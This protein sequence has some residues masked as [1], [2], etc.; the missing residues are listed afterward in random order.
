MPKSSGK[1][2]GPDPLERTGA[3]CSN[4]LRDMKNR[5]DPPR[6]QNGRRA[7]PNKWDVAQNLDTG[8]AQTPLETDDGRGHYLLKTALFSIFAI[9]A[10]MV[11]AP[12]G[13]AGSLPMI[14]SLLLFAT[15]FAS[16]I[17]GLHNPL[18][19][20]HP[21]RYAFGALLL[22]TCASYMAMFSGWTGGSTV[23]TRAAADRWLLLLIASAGLMLTVAHCVH[24]LEGILRLVRPLLA[25]ALVCSVIAA[26]QFTLRINPVEWIQQMMPGFTYNGGD[27]TFQVRGTFLRVAGTTFTSIELAVVSAMLLPLSI[28]RAL[29]DTKGSKFI[30][31]LG[32]ALLAFSLVA[33]VSRSSVLGLVLAVVIFLPFLPAVARKWAIL[34]L[35]FAVLFVFLTIPGMVTTLTG[36]LIAGNAD[37]SIST[38]TNNYPRVARMINE[39]PLLGLGPGNYMPD[40]AI[41]FLDNQYLTAAVTLGLIGMVATILYLVIPSLSTLV[42][43]LSLKDEALRS[44]AGAIAAGLAVGAACSMTFDSLSF[45][46][47]A[48]TFPTLVGF[49]GLAWNLA[50][51]QRVAQRTPSFPANSLISGNRRDRKVG[52]R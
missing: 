48:L 50:R 7:K 21:G 41:Y 47:F 15:W 6:A 24:S 16:A 27:T 11:I 29:Y 20:K 4:L 35:P 12:L 23:A 30:H 45:P 19:H 34:I 43:A 44:F 37:P 9:P 2:W 13:A 36:S 10:S 8:L 39:N 40:F 42:A 32:S 28:W 38:R 3:S 14:L 5:L 31:W 46:V 17:F 22:A 51:N 33:T 49:G 18:W 1:G 52:G 26:L 25:G